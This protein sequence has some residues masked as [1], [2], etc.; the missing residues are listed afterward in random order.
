MPSNRPS[1]KRFDNIELNFVGDG[2]YTAFTNVTLQNCLFRNGRNADPFDSQYLHLR[3]TTNFTV[4][5]CTFLRD[6][7]VMGRASSSIGHKRR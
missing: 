1:I 2:T 6:S 4:D 3:Q 7:T 5:G